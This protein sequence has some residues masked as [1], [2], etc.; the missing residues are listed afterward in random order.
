[1]YGRHNL[2]NLLSAVALADFLNIGNSLIIKA[3]ASFRGV[4]RRQEIKGEKK[5]ILV[6]DDFAHHPTAV[7]ETI[8]AVREKYEGRR[9]IAAFEPR[10]NSSRRKTF[11]HD[12]ASSFDQADF[13]LI[14]EPP[15]M[16]KIPEEER[17]SS[18]KLVEDLKKQ[19]LEAHY[20]PE[21]SL[22]LEEL[23]RISRK[24]DVVLIMSNGAF[25]NLAANLLKRL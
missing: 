13:I 2:S 6:L 25:D 22:L 5:G 1:L 14:P 3:F 4:K 12:Y 21:T 24:G 16:E 20:F 8:R 15:M 10:S 11:Q 9:L 19:G 7:R 18:W 17:F 23:L